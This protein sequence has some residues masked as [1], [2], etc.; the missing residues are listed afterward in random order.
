MENSL[1]VKC[2]GKGLCG[3][4]CPILAKL[5]TG[6][7][8]INPELKQE[9]EGSSPPSVFIGS[10]LEYPA[11]N[12]GIMSLP[13]IKENAWI[14][15]S[16]N[17]WSKEEIS[18]SQI[19]GF[20]KSLIN[21]RFKSDVFS[22]RKETR[23]LRMIQE[24]GMASI[25]AD[26]E[27]KLDKKPQAK[28]EF[29]D[30]VLPMGPSAQLKNLKIVSNTK[31][32]P[33][34]EKVY[35]DTDLKSVDALNYLYEKGF[36]E[37]SLS[38][39]LSV[40]ATGLKKDRKLVPTRNSITAIDDTL[41]KSLLVKIRDYNLIDDYTIY[42]GGHLGNYYLILC[43]PEIFS[44][45]LFEMSFPKTTW[46][47]TSRIE[48][49]TDYESYKGRKDY[50]EETS[51]GYYAARCSLLQHLEGI[52]RQASVLALRFVLPEYDVPLG[53]WVCRN[54]VRKSLSSPP[55]HFKTKEEMLKYAENFIL[56]KMRFNIKGIFSQSKILKEIKQPKL[57]QF[58]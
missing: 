41:G 26:I 11:V 55:V 32:S 3:K 50:A 22:I 58:L 49:M 19:I 27:V 18:S 31:I 28:I 40:G 2:K 10:K 36:D 23:L 29:S 7:R 51:G 20:R 53:V 13:E 1:C 43:F 6:V 38:Q 33:F 44:Y 47:P 17:S 9:F 46:N 57:T 5:G 15:D 56:E 54:S 37:H 35:F 4:Q 39:L 24:V 48:I 14:Y 16:P 8:E 30:H 52:K 12:V 45:E 34:I 21:S 25:Q 42:F